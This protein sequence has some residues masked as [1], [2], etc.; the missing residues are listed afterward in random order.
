MQAARIF[1]VVVS[2]ALLVVTILLRYHLVDP[3]ADSR[4]K[5]IV[6][7]NVLTSP[8]PDLMKIAAVEHRH[9]WADLFWL[10]IVQQLG[11]REKLIDSVWPKV[12]QWAHIATDL[13]GLYET[14][15][16]AVSVHLTVYAKRIKESD[17]IAEKGWKNI[18][19]AWQLPLMI[20]YNAYFESGNAA[21]GSE[22]IYHASRIPGSPRYLPALA[23][24]MQFHSG[25]EQGAVEVLEMM[26]P[27]LE[28]P[29]KRDAIY[30]MKAMKSEPR[31]RLFDEACQKFLADTGTT[32]KTGEQLVS[33]GY[34]NAVPADEF[35]SAIVFSKSQ[36]CLA[37]TEEIDI[38]ESQA[39]ERFRRRTKGKSK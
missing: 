16:R 4:Q 18:P 27:T 9:M 7:T 17:E 21:R 24:R 10:E 34:L 29:A 1:P 30:R 15:Y 3:Q 38:R 23:G 32:A 11:T 14:I 20:G 31:L 5:Q 13:D 37:V 36:E 26:I 33:A 19:S 8:G 2:A 39:K 35:G 25:D 22:Y 12:H 6:D 28:G